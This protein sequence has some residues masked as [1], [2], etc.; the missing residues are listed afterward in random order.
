MARV[1]LKSTRSESKE[2]AVYEEQDMKV[3]LVT[4]I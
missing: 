3:S 1:I 4:W 2:L